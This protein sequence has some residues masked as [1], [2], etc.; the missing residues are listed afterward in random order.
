MLRYISTAFALT[1]LLALACSQ[2]LQEPIGD[3]PDGGPP[4]AAEA[5]TLEF[6][7]L[8]KG[9]RSP[10]GVQ[11]IL[12]TPDIGVGV[13]RVGF[14]LTS[15]EGFV[16]APAATVTLKRFASDDSK[17][18]ARETVTASY[19]PWPY[20]SRGLYAAEFRFD[21]PG[22]WGLD[23]STE[24]PD[25]SKQTAELRF[26]VPD[27]PLAP[28]VGAQA[29]KSN[30]KTVAD[31]E[32]LAELTTGS[33]RDPDLYQ[34]TIADAVSSGLPTVVVF[35][36]P[37]FCTNEVCGPQ[38]EVLQQLKDKY[39]GRAN[40][41]HVDFYDNPHEIQGDLDKA[42]L[43]PV[44]LEWK[45]SS[46]E[47]SFVIASDGTITARFEGFATFDEVEQALLRLV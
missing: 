24:A 12:G 43:S 42:V 38:L 17:G 29:I 16:T 27:A 20:G 11:A 15:P 2:E 31:V 30:S 3:P 41:I 33:T 39:S 21:S 14:V 44:V 36:S 46:I 9:P 1:G 18:E 13:H 4:P 37:A 35:A 34:T 22:G 26:E 7:P 47:W 32:S 6:A 5:S 45:L 23:I 10:E 19:H 8:I 25:G 28:A 40:F